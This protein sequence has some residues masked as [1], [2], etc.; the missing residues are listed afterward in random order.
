MKRIKTFDWLRALSIIFIVLY[1]YTTRYAESIGHIGKYPLNFTYGYMGVTVFFILSGFLAIYNFNY[2]KIKYG[3]GN[4]SYFIN[5]FKRLYPTYWVGMILTT[6]VCYLFWR[7]RCVS[8]LEF[9]VNLTMLQSFFFVP[10]VDGVYWFL[11]LELLFYS[12][13]G[14]FYRF[15][16][17]NRNG[18]LCFCFTWIVLVITVNIL[19]TYGINNIVL[20]LLGVLFIRADAQTFIAGVIMGYTYLKRESITLLQRYL[21]IITLI[22]CV[23]NH[24]AM[25]GVL[26]GCFFMV[27]LAIISL[28]VG[29]K[30]DFIIVPS[31]IKFI[32]DISYPLYLTH[33]LI[34]WVIIRNL[35]ISGYTHEIYILIP[36]SIMML[37]AA[38]MHYRIEIPANKIINKYFFNC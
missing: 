33:Q 5:R 37:V 20:K 23:V 8:P 21:L 6:I 32:S 18:I 10:N 16:L 29:K 19:R 26:Y 28:V 1:H 38:V 22:L 17:K 14:L 13:I 25:Q 34:G 35:E 3:G 31:I 2:N 12:Y 11:P 30:L 9:L 7:E 36:I 4:W 27:I 15:K 24:F